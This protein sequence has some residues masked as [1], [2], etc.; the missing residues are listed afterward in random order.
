MIGAGFGGLT[1]A[2][3]LARQGL[4]VTLLEKNEGPGGRAQVY[5]DGGF[6]FD[7]GPSWYLMPDIFDAFFARIGERAEDYYRVKRLDPSYRIFF[8]PEDHVD[9][10]S[11]LEKNVT[12]F[13][14]IEPGC[15]PR[16]RE[17]LRVAEHKYDVSIRE[18]LYKDYRNVFD[19]LNRRTMMEGRD[20]HVFENLDKYTRRFFNSERLRRV[21]EYSM[22]FLGG[23][24]QNTP[25][26]Y[27]LMSHVDFNLGVWYPMG[28]IGAVV[29]AFHKIALS[30]GVKVHFGQEVRKIVERG[31]K[32]A[33]VQTDSGE[34]PADI[35]VVNAD[36]AHAET[37]LLE[38]RNRTYPEKYWAK[39]T[40]APSAFMMYLGL[41]GSVPNLAHHT[42]SFQHDWV[43]HFD[44]IFK[45]PAWPKE[46]S[47]YINC[48]SKT[49]PGTAPEGHE[50]MT[51][52][53][54]IAPGLTDN[55]ETRACFEDV[56]MDQVENLVGYPLGP[57][58]VSK[59]VF[60]PNDFAG[61]FN[62]Y[63]G[64]ALGLS[65]TLM[66][67]AAFRPSHRSRKVKNLYYTGQ[68]THPGIGMPMT[69]ISSTVVSDLIAQ[70]C[71]K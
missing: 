15:G 35:V 28:G 37:R 55:P 49:D 68:Y 33:G 60:G 25:A 50:T 7:M 38:A 26:L 65:H 46:P 62:A 52:L 43:D 41:K 34:F 59:R 29:D 67:S 17:Y 21:L 4:D 31:G 12:L 30:S 8:G 63:K 6:T 24:P 14:S 16:F 32:V 1:A 20:L 71:L 10:A 70:E 2:I 11:D 5:R 64:T 9:I 23:S 13:E 57:S 42:L 40:I 19:F 45:T 3:L 53:V 27:S 47:I 58:I 61:E 18:F 69:I 44:S 22:V 39:R 48:P 36:Y 51:V 56:V 54:P 66:Q